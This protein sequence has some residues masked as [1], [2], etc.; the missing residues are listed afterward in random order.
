MA[1][2]KS[3]GTFLSDDQK[4]SCKYY[5][6]TPE[7]NPK[8]IVQICHGMLEYMERYEHVA[9]FL[10]EHGYI[11]CGEDHLGHGNTAV[12][13]EDY[14][15]FGSGGFDGLVNNVEKLRLMMRKR[16]RS[17]PYIM[18]GH[19]MGSFIVRQYVV[20]YKNEIDALV[21]CGTSGGDEPL[22]VGIMLTSLLSKIFG[23]RYRS[24]F[25]RKMSFMGYNNRFIDEK[26]PF[27]WLTRDKDCRTAF[28]SDPKVSFTFTLNGYN[29]MLRLLKSVSSEEWA[30]EVPKG[31]PIYMISG[32]EDPVGHDGKGVKAVYDR[33]SE[34]EICNLKIKLYEGAR[35][36]LFNEINREEVLSDL[37]EWLNETIDSIREAR[38]QSNIFFGGIR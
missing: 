33:L 29:T 25:V 8:A 24:N 26:D 19:S 9:A 27:S 38:M 3:S 20:D 10:T 5:I 13:P 21:I 7:A 34:A 36:E 16:Y 12:T 23:E 11:V 17:L 14:G 28:A 22:T 1:Y 30:N 18:L 35:H 31:L 37:L 15:Y 4:T 32:T 6:Y 2:T